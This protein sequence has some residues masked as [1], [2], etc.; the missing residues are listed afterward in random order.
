MLGVSGKYVQRVERGEENVTVRSVT[1]IA[2][3]L[4]VPA[5]SLFMPP[6]TMRRPTAGRPKGGSEMPVISRASA[7]DRAAIPLMGMVVGADP[8]ASLSVATLAEWVTLPGRR[9]GKGYFVARVRG[10]SMEPLVPDGSLVLFRH[11]AREV[12]GRMLLVER[13]GADADEAAQYFLKR[14]R[15]Q[16][17]GRVRL[18]SLDR[19]VPDLVGALAPAGE[20]RIVAELVEVLTASTP[21]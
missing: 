5:P 8:A 10:A 13:R 9:L 21:P 18:Q 3:A 17:D 1:K 11:P 20:L 16:A 12:A 14:V 4:G 6:L 7:F 2:H 15:A 19:G